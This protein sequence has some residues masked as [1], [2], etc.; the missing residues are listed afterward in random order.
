M[1][2]SP[3]DDLASAERRIQELT[4]EL[5]QAKGEL[6]QARGELGEARE[7]QAATGGILR[8]ISNSPSNAH[9]IFQEIAATAARLCDAYDAGVLQCAGDHLRQVAH[10]GQIPELGQDT[11]PL[12]RGLVIGRAVLDQTIIQVSDL[13]AE[14][15]EY[16]LGSENARRLGHR[17][18]LAVPLIRD[19]EAI[20]AIFVRR[21]EVRPFTDRQIDLLKTFADQAVIAIDNTRLFEE[22]GA[23]TRELEE[24]L[25]YQTATGDVLGVISRSKFDLQPVLQSVVKT[26]VRLCRADHAMIYRLS[27]G[28]YQFAAS[29]GPYNPEYLEIER[30]ERIPLGRGTLVGRTALAKSAVQIVDVLVDPHYEKKEDARIAKVRSI[31]G[32]PLLRDGEAIGVIGLGRNRVEPYS[33]REVKLVAA[34]A[35]QAVIAIENTRLFEAE[36]ARTREVV[37]KSTELAQSLEYQTAISEVLSVISRSPN[38]LQPVFNTIV[39]S[40]KRLLRSHGALV[41]RVVG[42]ELRLAAFNAISPEADRVLQN[43]FPLKLDGTNLAV[44]ALRERTPFVVQDSKAEVARRRGFRSLLIVP[45]LSK[46]KAIGAVHVSRPEPGPFSDEEIGLLKTFADQAVIAIENA[47]LFEAEQASKRELQESL[48]YRPQLAR[49]FP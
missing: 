27:E 11:L 2:A 39:T 22:A 26:A 31:L 7:Q 18:I 24:S 49:F 10:R 17:T 14:T 13:Q 38:E 28:T 42:Q 29:Y 15:E 30:N 21:T 12:S 43:M 36:Q 16:P 25:E 45:M 8:A 5:S 35:D 19:R 44:A 34:F 23:R 48:E 41:T 46:G 9:E 4:N 32:V 20:G 33:E 47:R 6:S 40:S 37:V 1:T 3:T